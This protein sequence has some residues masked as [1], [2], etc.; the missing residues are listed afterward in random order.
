[1]KDMQDMMMMCDMFYYG[2]HAMYQY[3]YEFEWNRT[4]VYYYDRIAYDDL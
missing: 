2:F 1:M 4:Y 3:V